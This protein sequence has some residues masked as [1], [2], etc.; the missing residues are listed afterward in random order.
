MTPFLLAA[1]A[2]TARIS[3]LQAVAQ[4]STAPTAVAVRARGGVRI[5]GR[6]DE[7]AWKA[8]TPV[9][10]FTQRDPDAGRP[11]TERTEVRIIYDAAA[12]YIGARLFDS[13]GAVRSRLGRRDSELSGS[14]W[15]F[16][17]L[18]SY[19]DHLTAYRFGV[20]P[21]GVRRDEK[22][23]T[24][25]DEDES[26]DPI[27]EA[28]ATR[29]AAGW[30]A[31]LRIP[32]SQLRFR[33]VDEQT[34]GIQLVRQIARNN[35][36]SWFA[37]VPKRE[38]AVVGRYGHLTGMRGLMPR[39][40]LELLPYAVSRVRYD[41]PAQ[42]EDVPFV[43]PF[44]DGSEQTAS[45]GLD[46]KYRLAS[47]VTLDATVNPDFGQVEVDPAVLNLSAFETFFPEKRPFFVEGA[48]IFD[49][50]G[51]SCNFCSNVEGMSSFYS[52]RVGRAPTGASLAGRPRR[53][54]G[55][56]RC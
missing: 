45:L 6:L 15:F 41:T 26:W 44:R 20:N 5:D 30:M 36:E 22:V 13:T 11:A 10:S 54:G 42:S 4:D 40:R 47:N 46:L 17:T 35:E 38:R 31:E 29:D 12:I 55:A 19:H 43:N 32:L 37:F 16:V 48:Q 7:E 8:A 18:D 49:F 2:L 1:L 24:E 52:R 14:D 25:T 39:G 23:S 28:A 53:A 3:T 50:G 56:S 9:T 33:D 27:W 34:W 51:F 21:S